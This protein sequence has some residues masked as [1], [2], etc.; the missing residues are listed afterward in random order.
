MLAEKQQLFDE[1][2]DDVSLDVASRLNRDEIFGLFGLEAPT[3][4]EERRAKRTGL[5]LEERCAT[6][7][8]AKGWSV[9]KTPR[10]RD[11]GIDLIATRIDEIGLEQRIYLQCKDYARAVGVEVVRE[12]LG[13]IPAGSSTQAVLA[14]PAGVTADAGRLARERGVRIWD[15]AMLL[16]FESSA[17]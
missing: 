1:I 10:T 15:E 7:L 6:I 13:V 9:E 16:D 3:S 8:R 5:E 4:A 12:L 11:G 2:I 17:P 14:A